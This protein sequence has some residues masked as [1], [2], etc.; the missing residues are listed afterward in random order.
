MTNNLGADRIVHVRQY[1][2]IRDQDVVDNVD[3]LDIS[4][5]FLV[6]HLAY[7]RDFSM[8]NLMG[9]LV[10]SGRHQAVAGGNALEGQPYLQ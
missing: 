9:M 2:M 4:D 10:G 5:R 1:M 6:K 7:G 3:S 8:N